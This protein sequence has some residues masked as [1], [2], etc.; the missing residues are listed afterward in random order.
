MLVTCK[1]PMRNRASAG[2]GLREY[3]N[4]LVVVAQHMV[5]LEAVELALEIS[6]SLAARRHLQVDTI[7]V[8]HDLT[9]DQLRVAPDLEMLDPEFDSD[10]ETIDQ[11]FV[12]SG[13][14]SCREV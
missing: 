7:L 3:V 1:D 10:P 13:V 6:Y 5:Q 14:V 4:H 12:L 2:C 8:L 9:H 11:G